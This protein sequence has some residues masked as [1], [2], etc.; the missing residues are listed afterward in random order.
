MKSR[1]VYMIA[2]LLF[3]ATCMACTSPS[4]KNATSSSLVTS[5]SKKPQ[6]STD[7]KSVSNTFKETIHSD[8]SV[9]I[10]TNEIMYK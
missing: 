10:D 5:V 2:S 1:Q 8:G 3:L 6:Q 4:M 9:S 7:K